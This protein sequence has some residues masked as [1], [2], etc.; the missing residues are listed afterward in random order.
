VACNTQSIFV[1]LRLRQ[2][3]TASG[4]QS[5][6][7]SGSLREPASG[8]LRQ[9]QHH[10]GTP[11]TCALSLSSLGIQAGIALLVCSWAFTYDTLPKIRP[12][13]EVKVSSSSKGVAD[14]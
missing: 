8:S 11:A 1:T 9:P 7:A 4:S 12:M 10:L 2:P 3:Q 5:E 13:R 6:P 14:E